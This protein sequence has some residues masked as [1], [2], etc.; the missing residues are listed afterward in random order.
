MVEQRGESLLTEGKEGGKGQV[1][2]HVYR[3]RPPPTAHCCPKELRQKCVEDSRLFVN[4]PLGEEEKPR[5]PSRVVLNLFYLVFPFSLIFSPAVLGS[6]F[7]SMQTGGE[8]PSVVLF[9]AFCVHVKK[10][11]SYSFLCYVLCAGSSMRRT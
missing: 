6:C 7:C 4:K 9:H 2:L 5:L 3:P 11:N 8:S 1:T 10:G